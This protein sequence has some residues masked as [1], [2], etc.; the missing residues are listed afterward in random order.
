MDYIDYYKVLGVAKNAEAK[1][2]KKAYRKL[3]RKYHP[4]VNPNNKD[5]EKKFK[6]INEA[7]E[8]LG[9]EENRKKYDEFGKDWKHADDIKKAQQQQGQRGQYSS[10]NFGGDQF[11]NQDF[12]DFFSSMFSGAGSGYRGGGAKYK[13]QDYNSSITLNLTDIFTSQQQILVVNGKK[14]RITI[15]AGVSNG[16][17]IKIPG[18]GGE[19]VHGGPSGDLYIEFVINNNTK[20]KSEGNNLHQKLPVDLYTAVLGG[21][22]F[23]ETLNGKIKLKI[24]PETPNG[25]RVKLKGKGLPIYKSKDQFGDLYITYDITIPTQLSEKEI[26]LFKELQNLE[27]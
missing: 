16:Q 24:L 25:K 9:N 10:Q 8:V 22:V 15:P 14:I 13:G 18:K 7:N 26:S 21:E 11:N 27:K 17:I 23:V 1:D 19:G 4:D 3:A 6:E 20:F 12:S 2:I 5:A